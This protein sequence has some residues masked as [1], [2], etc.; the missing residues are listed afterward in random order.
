MS[1]R[2]TAEAAEK[3]VDELLA[4]SAGW[5]S[6]VDRSLLGDYAYELDILAAVDAMEALR[7]RRG[8]DKIPI[9]EL[10]DST[11]YAE[12]KKIT[13]PVVVML[14]EKI[15]SACSGA[16]LDSN[17]YVYAKALVEIDHW[18][19][20]ATGHGR[21]NV[22]RDANRNSYLKGARSILYENLETNFMYANLLGLS[23][24]WVAGI[25]R[26]S[27]GS[28]A[29]SADILAVADAVKRAGMN[30]IKGKLE[31]RLQRK[32]RGM[33]ADIYVTGDFDIDA[34]VHAELLL[35]QEKTRGYG[36][37]QRWRMKPEELDLVLRLETVLARPE[38]LPYFESG[39]YDIGLIDRCLTD[40]VDP[41]MAVTIVE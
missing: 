38:V 15:D 7:I 34:R 40:G 39:V 12:L 29:V 3:K 25:D 41:S 10:S 9:P 1:K 17:Y 2:M 24:A 30:E 4:Q 32:L 8:Y 33:L 21:F 31:E 37:K 28:L 20:L 14:F 27:L 26:K 16:N 13:D 22:D 18:W 5:L 19:R 36:Y 6:E 35:W 23:D 11:P